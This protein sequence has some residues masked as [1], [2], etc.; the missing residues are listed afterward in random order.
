[1]RLMPALGLA[2]LWTITA[3]AATITS[4]SATPVSGSPFTVTINSSVAGSSGFIT[5]STVTCGMASVCSGNVATFSA[6]GTGLTGTSP[7]DIAIDG[8]LSGATPATGTIALTSPQAVTI[9][10]SVSAGAFSKT[11]LSTTLPA[12][13]GGT[14][15][16]AGTLGLSLAPGQTL[17]LPSSLSFTVGNPIS[18]AVP[19]PATALL[20]GTA[21]AGIAV[22]RR[23]K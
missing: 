10:F 17:T 15:S 7:F 13:P 16:I 8:T 6:T 5:N 9:P 20:L 22:V 19:E 12:I 2:L 3:S 4:F 21:L 18:A 11:I 1:M 23:R 14:F